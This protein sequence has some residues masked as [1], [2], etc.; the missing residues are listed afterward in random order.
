MVFCCDTQLPPPRDT[1]RRR[2]AVRAFANHAI[3]VLFFLFTSTHA[4]AETKCWE[5]IGY[6]VCGQSWH[7]YFGCGVSAEFVQQ[8]NV[9]HCNV[10]VLHDAYINGVNFTPGSAGLRTGTLS[11]VEHP[12]GYVI[13]PMPGHYVTGS[14][15]C[16]CPANPLN[17]SVKQHRWSSNGECYLCPE[18]QVWQDDGMGASGCRPRCSG[19]TGA[20]LAACEAC[21]VE[22]GVACRCNQLQGAER[23]LCR[24]VG[25]GGGSAC[26]Q[27]PADRPHKWSDSSCNPCPEETPH[28]WSS[29]SCQFCPEG[30][31]HRWA[32]GTCQVC[33]EASPF[34]VGGSC[35]VCPSARPLRKGARCLPDGDG[36]AVEDAKDNCPS[37]PNPAQVDADGNGKGDAC[38]KCAKSWKLPTG[39]TALSTKLE[40]L[41]TFANPYQG[42]KVVIES[43]LDSCADQDIEKVRLEQQSGG[44]AETTVQRQKVETKFVSATS[45][46]D[47]Y[48]GK[49]INTGKGVFGWA[50]VKAICPP[51]TEVL[52]CPAV[53]SDRCTPAQLE[54]W[55]SQEVDTL[56]TNLATLIADH[57]PIIATTNLVRVVE[58]LPVADWI[59][60]DAMESPPHLV[61]AP[62][63][64]STAAEE[65]GFEQIVASYSAG[66]LSLVD[67]MRIAFEVVGCGGKR[68]S[69][70]QWLKAML[71]GHNVLKNT[72]S[73]IRNTGGCT[74]DIYSR[75][76]VRHAPTGNSPKDLC[77]YYQG[78]APTEEIR[79]WLNSKFSRAKE[80]AKAIKVL[81]PNCYDNGNTLGPAY[82]LFAFGLVHY[83]SSGLATYPAN[84]FEKQAQDEVGN[85]NDR[86]YKMLNDMQA[87][88]LVKGHINAVN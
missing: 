31:P 54:T 8:D 85:E 68:C 48:F 76:W 39:V 3:F 33:P 37:I 6:A 14:C 30:Q 53:T 78:P 29:G 26:F 88:A 77:D 65:D 21:P 35:S 25:F 84:F 34:R 4:L 41:K 82:H 56:E 17:P 50:K 19:L 42:D 61:P 75:G 11:K 28:K 5:L 22:G 27:C 73:L 23:E 64:V 51:D 86:V 13:P 9:V 20:A 12:P 79:K 44:V 52:S 40:K 80:V 47:Q 71:V 70:E 57:Y 46:F 72:A 60:N 63:S 24:C 74:P 58:S 16:A 32:N 66:S 43:Y 15:N 81:R 7:H 2:S 10:S 36:D 87:E 69:D 83:Y 38:D 1:E 18:G 49:I 59:Q 55:K 67:L 62:I 45:S